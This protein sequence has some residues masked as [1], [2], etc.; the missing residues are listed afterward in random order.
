MDCP[1]HPNF[2]AET[3]AAMRVSDGCVVVLDACEGIMMQ[4][5]RAI[6]EAVVNE[7][8]LC[9]VVSKMDRLITELKLP[10]NDAYYKLRHMIGRVNEIIAESYAGYRNLQVMRSQSRGGNRT[11]SEDDSGPPLISPELGNACFA[12]GRDRWCFTLESVAYRVYTKQGRARKK[13]RR[14]KGGEKSVGSF[15][16]PENAGEK[17]KNVRSSVKDHVAFAKNLWGDMYFDPST[18]KIVDH[19]PRGLPSKR[20]FVQFVLE[21]LWKLYGQILSEDVATLRVTLEN[22]LGVSFG[23]RN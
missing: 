23:A 11:S 6:H 13:R 18:G 15:S 4:T 1:G 22:N 2:C 7:V 21:P 8:P 19:A 14:R 3:T 12:S 20:T 10:P 17:K 16:S 5:E 9:L